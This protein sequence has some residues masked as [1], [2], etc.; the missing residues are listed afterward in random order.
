NE[1]EHL[2]AYLSDFY[3][4]ND[5]VKKN[6]FWIG[7]SIDNSTAKWVDGTEFDFD[8]FRNEGDEEEDG[9]VIQKDNGQT[10]YWDSRRCKKKVYYVCS[11]GKQ[12]VSQT[13]MNLIT[14]GTRKGDAKK[15]EEEPNSFSYA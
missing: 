10:T 8:K 11:S 6:E 12:T 4:A 13:I 2:A 9:C 15:G 1:Q 3:E 7:L 5:D 14:K